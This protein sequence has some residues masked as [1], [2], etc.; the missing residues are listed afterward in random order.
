VGG[1]GDT[2]EPT[3]A[4]GTAGTGTQAHL[5]P[6][7]LLFARGQPWWLPS[8]ARAGDV[9]VCAR[10]CPQEGSRASNATVLL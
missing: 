10:R 8:V 7:L 9:C 6:L 2:G 1:P 5:H 3:G 4:A